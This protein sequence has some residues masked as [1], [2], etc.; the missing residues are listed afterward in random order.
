MKHLLL[1]D[2]GAAMPVICVGDQTPIV[3]NG[4]GASAQSAVISATEDTVVRLYPSL[5]CYILFGTDPT[6]TTSSMP[7][8]AKFPE[9]FVV[10]AGHKIACLNAVLTIVKHRV[11]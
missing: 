3:V 11:A 1:D 9:Y 8:T 6:A 4:V 5:D 7:M 10:K 2:N